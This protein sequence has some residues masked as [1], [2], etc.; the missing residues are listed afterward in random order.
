VGA[1]VGLQP[2]PWTNFPWRAATLLRYGIL[3]QF[4]KSW[5][6]RRFNTWL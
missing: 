5:Y 2:L 6:L 4:M 1:V 3:T